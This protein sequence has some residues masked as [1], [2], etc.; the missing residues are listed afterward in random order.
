MP[1]NSR[2]RV[3]ANLIWSGAEVASSILVSLLALL[4]IARLIGATEF[5]LGALALGIVQIFSVVLGS[6]FHDALVQTS[7]AD[8]RHFNAAWTASW[9]LG[10]TVFCLCLAL[11][12]SLAIFFEQPRFTTVFMALAPMLAV[13]GAVSILMAERRRQMDF[14][15]VALQHLSSRAAGALI[16]VAM[17]WSGAGV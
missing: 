16:G 10:L 2:W 13:A 9:M 14:R 5:G 12:E 15:T 17:A 4:G 3:A 11:A 6:L 8:A 7:D 1:D